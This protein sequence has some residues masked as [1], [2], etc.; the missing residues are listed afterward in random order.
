M[1]LRSVANSVLK[2]IGFRLT[3]LQKLRDLKQRV[4]GVER[5]RSESERMYGEIVQATMRSTL[6]AMEP[7][8]FLR[9]ILNGEE[10]WLPR[11]TLRTMVHCVHL[12]PTDRLLL[13][14]E[15]CHLY[16][17]M[18]RLAPGGCLVDVGA[19]SGAI[20]LPV[21]RRFGSGVRIIT[22]EPART[23]LGLLTTTLA[24]NGIDWVEVRPRAVSD[25]PGTAPFLEFPQDD[26]GRIPYLPETSALQAGDAIDPRQERYDVPVTTLDEEFDNDFPSAPVVMKID[27]EGFETKVLAGASEFLARV[28]P[29][30]SIDIHRDPFV[31]GGTTEP[32]VR[33]LL[34]PLGYDCKMMAHVLVCN[35]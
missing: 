35:V 27:V 19:A 25:A 29:A 9:V 20:A 1:S 3:N 13:L 8:A 26:T 12:D 16:W 22:F 34:E 23:A 7:D 6:Q 24:R 11:D 4:A 2:P 15:N 14:V 32:A 31:G 5:A 21:A 18:E 30:L 17:M 33:A 28:R 10:M